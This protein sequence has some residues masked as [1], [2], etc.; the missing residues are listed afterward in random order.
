M[1]RPS[2]VLLLH[3][4]ALVVTMFILSVLLVHYTPTASA[5]P[6][7][8]FYTTIGQQQLF[9]NVLAALDQADYV[10]P[11]QLRDKLVSD[12]AD[13]SRL[14]SR[15][16]PPVTTEDPVVSATR[17]DLSATLTRPVT[18][19]G[20]DQFTA[21]LAH[22]YGVE[23]ARRAAVTDLVSRVF[24][25]RALGREGCSNAPNEIAKR[26]YGF[27]P[28]SDQWGL[29]PVVNGAQAVLRSGTPEEK[30]RIEK[31]AKD[32]SKYSLGATSNTDIET[33]LQK[34]SNQPEKLQYLKNELKLA[35]QSFVIGRVDTTIYDDINFENG[36]VEFTKGPAGSGAQ[37]ELSNEDFKAWF[38]N[39]L[40]KLIFRQTNYSAA[41]LA[42]YQT[43]KQRQEIAE[44]MGEVADVRLLAQG[45]RVC[46]SNGNCQTQLKGVKPVIEVPA[47]AKVAQ[48]NALTNG[49]VTLDSTIT[50]ATPDH[51]TYPAGRAQLLTRGSR[52]PVNADDQSGLAPNQVLGA[53]TTNSN[54]GTVAGET[55]YNPADYGPA[56]ALGV[57][58]VAPHREEELSLAL[59]ALFPG[60]A[61][62]VGCDCGLEETANDFGAPILNKI[63]SFGL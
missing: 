49:L 52:Q 2:P 56:P 24:C 14:N 48:V 21:W 45:E 1:R 46:D 19:E 55:T 53:Q 58:A 63:R 20:D 8:V 4:A 18:L 44:A 34:A 41:A 54:E 25:Q 16:Q 12:R 57:S 35:E 33:L 27:V 6:H 15:G 9:F 11:K 60:F 62:N 10:E 23:V 50:A 3:R 22:Q 51:I 30:Q 38:A 36:D 39:T 5:D 61:S 37:Q 47:A 26:S 29:D 32:N 59:E 13:A 31:L 40:N 42:G 43:I 17:S 28:D 7:A